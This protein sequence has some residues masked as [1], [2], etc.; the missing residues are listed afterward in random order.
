MLLDPKYLCCDFVLPVGEIPQNAEC[1]INPYIYMLC[2]STVL[3]K[4]KLS[5]CLIKH[6]IVKAYDFVC[7]KV[8]HSSKYVIM[9]SDDKNSL[10]EKKA[11]LD[12]LQFRFILS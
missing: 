10:S 8:T 12:I 6:F 4:I 11:G 2:T 5:L 9:W 3:I 7:R 1:R